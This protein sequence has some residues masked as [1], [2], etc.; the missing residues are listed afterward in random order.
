MTLSFLK[1]YTIFIPPVCSDMIVLHLTFNAS[2]LILD[3]SFSLRYQ[4]RFTNHCTTNPD[5]SHITATHLLCLWQLVEMSNDACIWL[6]L[7]EIPASMIRFLNDVITASAWIITYEIKCNT[8]DV[9]LKF[10]AHRQVAL[11]FLGFA[12]LENMFKSHCQTVNYGK[13]KWV[14]VFDYISEIICCNAQNQIILFQCV[15]TYFTWSC[16]LNSILL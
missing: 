14:C 15:I 11:T 13:R 16:F 9:L 10:L 5:K 8:W 1:Y 2:M 6:Y 12:I 7:S 3:V 4:M